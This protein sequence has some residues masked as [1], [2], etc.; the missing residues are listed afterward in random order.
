VSR[1]ADLEEDLLLAFH[2]QLAVVDT[3]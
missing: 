3:P 2:Q 1:T